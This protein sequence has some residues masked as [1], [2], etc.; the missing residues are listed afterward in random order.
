[1]HEEE[2]IEAA[3]AAY[4][5]RAHE[6]STFLVGITNWFEKHPRLRKLPLP[7][8]HSV[9]ARMK[10]PDHLREKLNRKKEVGVQIGAENL[11]HEITDLAGVR[12]LH[13][14]QEQFRA[15][16]EEIRNKSEVLGDWYIAEQPRAYTW[17]PESQQ[18]FESLGIETQVK[19]SFYTSVHYLIRPRPD[20]PICC[21]IQVRTLFEEIWGEIDHSLNY[22]VPCSNFAC[23]EQIRVLAKLVGAGSRLVDSIFR[24]A[25][26]NEQTTK[27][28]ARP[29]V[30]VRR[31]T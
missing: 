2:R 15:I 21:E 28:E 23:G 30:A 9:K 31:S 18:F 7:I 6:I 24:S 16:H 14:Y 29:V 10:D 3:L 11:F 12:V 13:I 17:D 19:E 8:I 4:E 26:S 20:S 27:N 22:P 5:E 1:M 25:N